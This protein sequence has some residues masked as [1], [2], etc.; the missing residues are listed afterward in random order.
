MTT[1]YERD[2]QALILIGGAILL[3]VL[4]AWWGWGAHRDSLARLD[5]QVEAARS[6]LKGFDAKLM[7]YQAL[8][9]S[10]NAL[11]VGSRGK[12]LIS[13][14]ED[15]AAAVDARAQLA[16]VRPQPDNNRDGLVEESVEIRL[17]KLQLNQLVE[18]LYRFETARSALKISQLRLR[19]RFENPAQ[20]DAVIL[21]SR[22]REG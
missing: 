21:L 19:T 14:V 13:S 18:L 6:E 9:R 2:R 7:E 11:K 8:E 15:A 5:R 17:E 16:Y 3:M 20:L 12:S 22:F 1:N 4:L 10:L